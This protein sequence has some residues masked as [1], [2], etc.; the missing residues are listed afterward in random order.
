MLVRS[1]SGVV[2]ETVC[3]W[4]GRSIS[5]LVSESEL[6][7]EES[8]SELLEDELEDPESMLTR[9]GPCLLLFP[10]GMP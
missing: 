10:T 7:D 3:T 4:V 6:S 8:E 5:M 9:I 2:D 1:S